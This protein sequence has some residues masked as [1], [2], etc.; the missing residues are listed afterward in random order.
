MTRAEQMNRREANAAATLAFVKQH[1]KAHGFGPSY[2]DI[3]AAVG[4]SAGSAKISVAML[5]ER[6]LISVEPGVARS[7]RPVTRKRAS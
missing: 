5:A 6:G 2:R 3:Q 1:C 7:I 4:I